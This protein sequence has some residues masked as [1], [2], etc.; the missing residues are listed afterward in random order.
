[1]WIRQQMRNGMIN[2]NSVQNIYVSN[3][4]G[5]WAVLAHNVNGT[6]NCLGAYGSQGEAM[7]RMDD[8]FRAIMENWTALQ[9]PPARKEG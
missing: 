6:D 2:T 9:M 5:T 1:M 3:K 7:E 8:I 4:K